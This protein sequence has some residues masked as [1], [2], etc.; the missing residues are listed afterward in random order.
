MSFEIDTALDKIDKY[1]RRHIDE[2][3]PSKIAGFFTDDGYEI[4]PEQIKIPPLCLS[5]KRYYQPGPEDD[6]L[7]N[8]CR[9]DQNDPDNFQCGSFEKMD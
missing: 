8:L 5:C 4:S 6:I 2:M 7:C 9:I 3:H 1:G